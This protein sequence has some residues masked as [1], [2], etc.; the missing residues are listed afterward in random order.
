MRSKFLLF[1]HAISGELLWQPKLRQ[2]TL[3][4]NKI[5][6]FG[7]VEEFVVDMFGVVYLTSLMETAFPELFGQDKESSSL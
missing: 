1:K 7:E 4:L 2:D 6:L 5:K 3:F